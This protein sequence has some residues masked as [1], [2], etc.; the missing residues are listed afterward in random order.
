MLI[1]SVGW[2]KIY[3]FLLNVS[4]TNKKEP[5]TDNSLASLIQKSFSLENV[6]NVT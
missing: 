3:K 2:T 1:N 5:L 4:K 6:E